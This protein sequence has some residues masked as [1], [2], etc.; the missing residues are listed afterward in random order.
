M[1]RSMP[2]AVVTLEPGATESPEPDDTPT[3]SDDAE[4]SAP[5]AT[6]PPDEPV[7]PEDSDPPDD[8]SGLRQL[9]AEVVGLV[10]AERADADCPELRVDERLVAAARGHSEDMAERDYFDHT[11]PDGDGP[12]ERAREAGYQEW[13]GE[14]IAMGY[15]T[16]EAVVDGW[17]DSDGHRA[18]ILNC[19]SVA[20]G[21]GV[22]DSS[23]GLYW[24]Q[25][26]GRS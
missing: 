10:N 12:G 21:V 2:S 26:F 17:M 7:P 5:A 24:T 22:A 18:N 3:P 1:P 4:Q 9:E 6:T 25:T 15:P 20:T 16:A 13:S 19:E 23:R 14:N 11:S 8:G